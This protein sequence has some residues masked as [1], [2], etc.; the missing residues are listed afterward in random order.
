VSGEGAEKATQQSSRNIEAMARSTSI[1]AQG[2][3]DVSREY[4]DLWRKITARSL[5]SLEE[6]SRLRTPQEML[7]TQS[8]IIRDN[9][10]EFLHTARRTAETSIKI[11]DEATRGIAEAAELARRAA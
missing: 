7:A 11:A 8:E 1:L 6:L 5:G 4:L 2:L 9:V 10:Q 3:Q